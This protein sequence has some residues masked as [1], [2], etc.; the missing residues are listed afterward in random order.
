MIR[1]DVRL[2]IGSFL[3]IISRP[4]S[5]QTICE[6]SE[7]EVEICGSVWTAPLVV[8]AVRAAY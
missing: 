5:L 8:G 1:E 3:I 4:T 6:A 7:T 2:R